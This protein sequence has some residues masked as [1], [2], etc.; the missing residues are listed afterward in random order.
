MFILETPII[1]IG[2][3]A[4]NSGNTLSIALDSIINQDFSHKEMQLI[5]IDD[6]SE[7]NT[8]HIMNKYAQKTNIKTKVIH[9]DWQ[10]LGPARNLIIKKADG[11]FILWVDADEILSKSYVRKQVEYLTNNPA[12]GITA[13]VFGLVPR[14]LILNLEIIPFIIA[15]Y[16]FEQPASFLWKTERLLG[17]GGS[18]FRVEALK[19]VNGFCSNLTG[20]G[21]DVEVAQRIKKVGWLIKPNDALFFELHGGMS[22]YKDLWIKYSWRGLGCQKIYRKN[23]GLFSFVRMNPIAGIITGFLLSIRGY[24]LLHQKK[25]FLLPIHFGIKMTAWSFGFIKGQVGHK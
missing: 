5:L 8:F 14:K 19:Q 22:S 21:E 13:G 23:Q 6:G 10:G 17:T 1:T 2:M 4:R 18:T 15:H 11:D 9:T 7:D 20:A 24:K 3:C 12:V 25:V 16:D